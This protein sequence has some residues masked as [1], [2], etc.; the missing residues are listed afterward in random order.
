MPKELK[1]YCKDCPSIDWCLDVWNRY[2]YEKSQN[3]LGCSAP[4]PP[5]PPGFKPKP[6]KRPAVVTQP[7]LALVPQQLTDDDF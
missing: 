7:S 1:R 3:G 6:R 2:W 4:L 5:P